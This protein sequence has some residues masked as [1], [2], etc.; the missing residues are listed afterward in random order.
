MVDEIFGAFHRAVQVARIARFAV[1]H[2]KA[3][4]RPALTA[5]P[6][7]RGRITLSAALSGDTSRSGVVTDDVETTVVRA[8][9]VFERVVGMANGDVVVALVAG[10]FRDREQHF[11]VHHVVDDDPVGIRVA[12]FV[13]PR[14]DQPDGRAEAGEQGVGSV[15]QQLPVRL[16]SRQP[17]G[18]G[19]GTAHHE[20]QVVGFGVAAQRV[21]GRRSA[22]GHVEPFRVAGIFIKEPDICREESADPAPRRIGLDRSVRIPR[23]REQVG[24][25]EQ[26]VQQGGLPFGAGEGF[27]DDALRCGIS[28]DECEQAKGQYESKR[29]FHVFGGWFC[30]CKGIPAAF[31]PSV[32]QS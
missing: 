28:C 11:E 15:D 30:Q 25:S 19:A 20:P 27:A 4:E 12:V 32:R 7:R 21:E 26:R 29:L 9:V 22:A 3:V 5:R 1:T 31:K 14:T 24:R 13:V 8:E 16:L 18:C 6:G 17:V 23:S 10:E 2:R